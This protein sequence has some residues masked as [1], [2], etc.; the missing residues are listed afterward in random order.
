MKAAFLI[1][2]GK[3]EIREVETPK[4]QK[5]EV[6]IKIKNVGICG[7]DKHIYKKGEL[8]QSKVNLPFIL[9]HECS[10][11]VV[12]LG[13][14]VK[15]I[16][17]GDRVTVEPSITCGICEFCTRGL[18]NMCVDYKPLG[19]PPDNQGVMVEYIA[20]R[21]DRCF[22]LPENV[23]FEEGALIEPLSIVIHAL[24]LTNF[25]IGDEVLI[26]GAGSIG[27]LMLMLLKAIGVGRC[28]IS[29]IN[30]FKLN[31]ARNM[32]ADIAINSIEKNLKDEI[33]KATNGAGVPIIFDA[34]GAT[35]TAEY[36]ILLAKKG[37]FIIWI[38]ITDDKVTINITDLINKMLTVR[39]T[40]DFINDFP[41][42]ISLVRNKL[43]A[44]DSI[45]TD[46]YNFKDINEAFKYSTSGNKENIKTMI[47]FD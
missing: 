36:S 6:L 41:K 37:A 42:A 44:I 12:E 43:L 40:S 15:G 21:Y 18:Y 47:N 23:T 25:K 4:P 16:K 22:L 1:E 24:N 35:D 2:P 38:G 17:I 33:V 20:H 46:Y 26:L 27:L 9:G 28:F 30:N 3:I 32:G 31:L 14:D 45:V 39:G 11:E 5:N 7:S 29:S 19:L 34:V 10:G 8:A 13:K